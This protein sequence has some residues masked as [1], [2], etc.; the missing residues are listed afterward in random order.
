MMAV[1]TLK[2]KQGQRQ[3]NYTFILYIF[4]FLREKQSSSGSGSR[5]SSMNTDGNIPPVI[6]FLLHSFAGRGEV[7]LKLGYL[8]E[9]GGFRG[10]CDAEAP[11]AS[12]SAL[13]QNGGEV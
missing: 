6:R 7:T 4:F 9:I 11:A 8:K 12:V 3:N 1:K 5:R 10:K 13:C 2:V